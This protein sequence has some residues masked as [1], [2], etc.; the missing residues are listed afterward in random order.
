MNQEVLTEAISMLP[1]SRM[2]VLIDSCYSGAFAV[3][4]SVFQDRSLAGSLGQKTGRM[5]LAGTSSEQEASD[6]IPG[7]E[8]HGLFTAVVLNGLNGKADQEVRGNRD[9]HVDVLEIIEY[10][11][12][13]VSDEAHK[14]SHKQNATF[15]YSGG[16]FFNLSEYKN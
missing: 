6:G 15:Y 8:G 12:K 9:H 7:M 16:D 11:R 3:S 4:K 2:V 1:A 10:A 5:V 13:Q 14:I